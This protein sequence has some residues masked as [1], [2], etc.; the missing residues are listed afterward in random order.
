MMTE[1]LLAVY[2]DV[3]KAGSEFSGVPAGCANVF[4]ANGLCGEPPQTAPQWGDRVRAMDPGSCGLRPRIQLWHGTGDM[5]INY[6]NQLEAIKEWTNVL[7]LVTNPTTPS[8]SVQIGSHMWD[9]E[10]WQSSCGYTVLDV[11]T[12]PGGPHNTDA[13][14]NEQY[15]I[16]F[17]GLD[18]I[19]S[20][21]PEV[22]QCGS[23]SSSSSTTNS[24]SSSSIS[25][26]TSS[27]SGASSSGSSASSSG[28]GAKSS[29]ATSGSGGGMTGVTGRVARARERAGALGQ[30]ARSAA[31]VRLRRSLDVRAISPARPARMARSRL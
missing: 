26:S 19:G 1:L 8:T 7:G 30:A 4:D 20:T 18:D 15:V 17:L 10:S 6:Q 5:T 2:P 23:S 11:W 21:D 12:E 31:E 25:G 27:G 24:S 16:P 22:A 14:L 3:F 28:G 13:P 29:G 9:H